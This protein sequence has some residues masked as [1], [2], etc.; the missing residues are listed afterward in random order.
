LC[1]GIGVNTDIGR[2]NMGVDAA[3]QLIEDMDPAIAVS[4][5]AGF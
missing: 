1:F 5:I 4:L 2:V 3:V